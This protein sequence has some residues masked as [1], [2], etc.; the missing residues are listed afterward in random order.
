MTTYHCAIRGFSAFT[1]A[2]LA[3]LPAYGEMTL[4]KVIVDFNDGKTRRNDIE[5]TNRGK[6]TM[7]VAVSPAE[8][9]RPGLDGQQRRT[10]IDPR[11]LG[12]LVSPSRMVLEPGQSKP[13]RLSILDRPADRDRIYRVK[14]SPVVGRT[15][16]TRTGLRILVGY[17]VLVIVR[18]EKANPEIDGE[19][20]GRK[21]TLRN[22]GNSNVLLLSGKQC[23][24][25]KDCVD[26]P[27]TR[28]YAGATWTVNLPLDAP[29]EYRLQGGEKVY[30][31][32]F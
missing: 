5:V 17:D 3:A 27:T 28:L 32:K 11:E 29:A 21:L 31:R 1:I 25:A 26:L 9:T 4:D 6:E 2:F 20:N 14:I 8:I 7:Y 15:L 22:T 10:R 24:K 23:P 30:S 16:A 13:V 18:P 12:L 19:R